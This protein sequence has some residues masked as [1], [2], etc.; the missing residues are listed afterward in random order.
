MRRYT[1]EARNLTLLTY[2]DTVWRLDTVRHLDTVRCLDVDLTSSTVTLCNLTALDL[3]SGPLILRWDFDIH[4]AH[5]FDLSSALH[6]SVQLLWPLSKTSMIFLFIRCRLVS[7][8]IPLLSVTI[9]G[10]CDCAGI[11]FGL[12]FSAWTFSLLLYFLL[13]LLP[14]VMSPCI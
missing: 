10:H 1:F 8:H 11:M 13:F 6:N 9:L 12:F 4:S 7:D 5:G 3:F 2:L 14:I